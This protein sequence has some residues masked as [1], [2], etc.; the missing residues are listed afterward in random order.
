M[1]EKKIDWSKK[2]L[3]VTNERGLSRWVLRLAYLVQMQDRLFLSNVVLFTGQ[4]ATKHQW[5]SVLT[6]MIQTEYQIN[7]ME[8]VLFKRHDLD[9]ML[10]DIDFNSLQWAKEQT[11]AWFKELPRQLMYDHG[12]VLDS[13]TFNYLLG[14]EEINKT[15][16]V[17]VPK[18]NSEIRAKAR[19][20]A[21]SWFEEKYNKEKAQMKKHEV[22]K[23][24]FK[25][26]LDMW[27]TEYEWYTDD[28]LHYLTW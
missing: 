17:D 24:D 8:C 18:L 2:E 25:N 16:I 6:Y 13:K 3:I 4:N 27:Y 11:F 21:K 14:D 26:L 1:N 7:L 22:H 28:D 15:N 20:Y 12:Y 9:L 10:I 5:Q 19:D 23:D